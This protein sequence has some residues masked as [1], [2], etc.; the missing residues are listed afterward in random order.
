[1]LLHGFGAASGHWRRVAPALA[2]AGYHVHAPDL[3]GF[4]EASQPARPL[5]TRLWAQQVKAFLEEVVGA[6]P[7]RPAVLVGNSLGGLTGLTTAILA[8]GLVGAL[9]A[10][11]LPDPAFLRPVPER[12]P[13]WR[14]RLHRWLV[15]ALCRLLPLELIV[16]LIARTPLLGLALQSAYSRPVGR[17]TGLRRL[18]ARPARRAT[19]AAALR[20]MCVGMALRPR[21]ATAPDLLPRL[22]CPLL[23]LWGGSDRLVPAMITARI[24]PL[25][26]G[27]H[28][29]TVLPGGGHCLHDDLPGPFLAALLP[30]LAGEAVIDT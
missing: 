18:V 10:A 29:L 11:P 20:G 27:P 14:R 17:D 22:R 12:R 21:G 24:T 19:A 30:W 9:V 5:D 3:L 4:G 7:A 1:V 15:Q 23:L 2:D 13:P 6:G 25:L 26:R 28:R 16:P 8:P